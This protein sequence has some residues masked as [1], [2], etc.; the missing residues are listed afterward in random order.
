MKKIKIKK[1]KNGIALFEQKEVRRICSENNV[2][3]LIEVWTCNNPGTSSATC[4]FRDENRLK[5]DCG[6]TTQ[7]IFGSNFCDAN[8]DVA[9]SRTN[10]VRGCDST[11]KACFQ[12]TET[13]TQIVQDCPAN[14]PCKVI[15]NV[16][17]CMLPLPDLE[18][19]SQDI[20]VR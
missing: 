5:Q 13:E 20:V 9:H 17:Q 19:R 15:N 7:G 12:R 14:G 18:I 16:A 2:S 10:T 1:Q 3:H 11:T 8:L 4:T 6:E